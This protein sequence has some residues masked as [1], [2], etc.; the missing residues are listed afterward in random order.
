MYTSIHLLLVSSFSSHSVTVVVHLLSFRF[1]VW[2]A[3]VNFFLLCIISMPELFLPSCVRYR[4]K[5]LKHGHASA[6]SF[7]LLFLAIFAP[8]SRQLS[9]VVSASNWI[10][11]NRVRRWFHL[12]N[13]AGWDSP[14]AL[15]WSR[16]L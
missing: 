12:S 13:N 8:H 4:I 14:H 15:Q 5:I 1:I 7:S 11:R 9:R 16:L 6:M 10:R 3:Q 2:P